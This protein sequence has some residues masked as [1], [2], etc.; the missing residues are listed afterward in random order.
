[1]SCG[2]DVSLP[3][4][5][6]PQDTEEEEDDDEEEEEEEREKASSDADSS[7]DDDDDDDDDDDGDN[8]SCVFVKTRCQWQEVGVD[9]AKQMYVFL[10]GGGGR[11]RR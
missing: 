11:R 8:V 7:S 10:E 2:D 4:N 1:M 9:T 3:E 5:L 6:F